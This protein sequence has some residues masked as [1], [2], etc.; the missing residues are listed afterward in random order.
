MASRQQKYTGYAAAYV[1]IVVAILFG[2]NFLANRYNKSVDTTANKRFSLSDQTQKIVQGLKS[3]VKLTYFDRSEQFARAKDLLDRYS[4]LSPKLQVDYVDLYKKPQIARAAGVK[5]EGALFIETLGKK[6]EAKSITEEEITGALIRAMKGGE[7]TV[8][9]VQGSREKSLDDTGRTGY[10]RAKEALERSNYKTRSVAWLT[11]ASSGAEDPKGPQKVAV[12]AAPAAPSGKP[13]LPK[14]C[15]V[16]V[17]AGPRFDYP[18]TAVDAL[19][20][21][22]EGGGRLM[23]MLDP[24]LKLGRDDIA[25]NTALTAQLASWGV[26]LG[27]DL[28]VDLSPANQLVGLSPVVPLITSFESHPIVREM[29]DSAAAIAQMRT[30]ETKNGDKT[31]V[32][33]L[34]STGKS[35]FATENLSSAEIAFDPAKA[36]RGPFTGAAA[37]SHQSGAGQGRAVVIGSS[38]WCSNYLLGF[39]AN[40]DLFL[41][42][43]NWLSSDEDLISIRPKDPEDRRLNLSVAQ[44]NMI[45]WAAQ[46]LVPLTALVAGLAVWW[47]RR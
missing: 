23:V 31:T 26:T 17:V 29:R 13:E 42:M 39:N 4:V 20:G 46:L 6:E 30:M 2:V 25:D 43:M 1:A 12:D 3:D 24:P 16:V 45:T 21:H 38:D 19:K 44:T 35:S 15:T 22:V 41:N 37:I 40:R 9:F 47:K 33:K 28:V 27:K 7:R 10:S 18:Q 11:G 5:Q 14:D 36:K 8:C 34:F 32:D